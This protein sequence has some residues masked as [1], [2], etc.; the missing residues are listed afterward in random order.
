MIGSQE[1]FEMLTRRLLE[2]V[3][4]GDIKKLI[5]ILDLGMNINAQDKLGR[6]PI[7]LAALYNNLP[8]VEKLAKLGADLETKDKLKETILSTIVSKQNPYKKM[9][10]DEQLDMVKLL[11]KQGAKLTTYSHYSLP[12]HRAIQAQCNLDI[13]KALLTKEIINDKNCPGR[14]PLHLAVLARRADIVGLLIKCNT[15]ID[16]QEDAQNTPLMLAASKGYVDIAILLLVNGADPNIKNLH[17]ET[18]FNLTSSEELKS[19]ALNVM[20]PLSTDMESDNKAIVQ[21]CPPNNHSSVNHQ[22]LENKLQSSRPILSDLKSIHNILPNPDLL[23]PSVYT[24]PLSRRLGVSSPKSSI[25]RTSQHSMSATLGS[26]SS[27]LS[28]TSRYSTLA[29]GLPSPSSSLSGSFTNQFKR[30]LN[31]DSSSSSESYTTNAKR[32]KFDHTFSYNNPN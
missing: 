16:V 25:F 19:F 14:A 29:T 1:K 15:D 21:L 26:S 23:T 13:I 6:T 30:V 31:A 12:I 22:I 20:H 10:K 5:R 27:S 18:F 17:G 7:F 32:K 9:S 11:I 3:H 28:G 2:A 8:M 4:D 24:I